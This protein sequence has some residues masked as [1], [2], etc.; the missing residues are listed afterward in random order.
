MVG[1]LLQ[2]VTA[3]QNCQISW[4]DTA[5]KIFC[6]SLLRN[7]VNARKE[8]CQNKNYIRMKHAKSPLATRMPCAKISLGNASTMS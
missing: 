4:H 8:S 5:A 6:S 2:A 3:F 7:C 1:Q